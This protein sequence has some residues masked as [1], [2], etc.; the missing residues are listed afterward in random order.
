MILSA[1]IL[2]WR[3]SSAGILAMVVGFPLAFVTT[4]TGSL[5]ALLPGLDLLPD[6]GRDPDL[7]GSSVGTL[8]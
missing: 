4:G 7:A 8:D 6:P 3:F 5:F 2:I 1:E